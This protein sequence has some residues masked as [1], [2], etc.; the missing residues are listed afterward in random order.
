MMTSTPFRA[1]TTDI[2][3][4]HR[5]API[6]KP[7][8][9]QAAE[10]APPNRLPKARTVRFDLPPPSPS[11]PPVAT[12]I[13][14]SMAPHTSRLATVGVNEA[15]SSPI[16]EPFVP[17]SS[18]GFR[19]T[20]TPPLQS[21]QKLSSSPQPKDLNALHLP[22]VIDRESLAP[23]AAH[24][25]VTSSQPQATGGEMSSSPLTVPQASPARSVPSQVENRQAEVSQRSAERTLTSLAPPLTAVS[26]QSQSQSTPTSAQTTPSQSTSRSTKTSD[27][28]SARQHDNHGPPVEQS[29]RQDALQADVRNQPPAPGPQISS[30]ADQHRTIFEPP[31]QVVIASATE[32]SSPGPTPSTAAPAVGTS[33]TMH[34]QSHA[35]DTPPTRQEHVTH[36]QP[37]AGDAIQFPAVSSNHQKTHTYTIPQP[38]H[39][40]GRQLQPSPEDARLPLQPA[41]R[42]ASV[43]G[44]GSDATIPGLNSHFSAVSVVQAHTQGN[45]IPVQ[46]GGGHSRKNSIDV[47]TTRPIILHHAPTPQ[48]LVEDSPR[49]IPRREVFPPATANMPQLKSLPPE[50][51]LS[52]TTSIS[53]PQIVPALQTTISR[54]MPDNEILPEPRS[55]RLHNNVP[56]TSANFTSTSAS[57]QQPTIG[58]GSSKS[59]ALLD[60]VRLSSLFK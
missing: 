19:Q 23:S 37:A 24:L 48:I 11:P 18:S 2:E 43:S 15:R 35:A 1:R 5:F 53:T 60:E 57:S 49:E 17:P 46:S 44:K 33:P 10:A 32:S 13:G 41:E 26:S 21:D 38:E 25:P 7:S 16:L 28:P 27:A 55:A 36:S 29:S 56:L 45:A 31:R 50:P 6:P 59:R 58:S 3:T 52:V 39:G 8:L 51:I 14:S 34:P 9:S 22:R 54:D 12:P 40:T 42:S 20:P 30:A 4:N 47:N